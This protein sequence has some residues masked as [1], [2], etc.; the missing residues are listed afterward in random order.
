[1]AG[2]SIGSKDSEG[3]FV[4]S[5]DGSVVPGDVLVI[6]IEV[7]LESVVGVAGVSEM[8]RSE[9]QT[10]VLKALGGVEASVE[11]PLLSPVFSDSV[12]ELELEVVGGLDLGVERSAL[13]KIEPKFDLITHTSS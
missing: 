12:V 1:M 3:E 11:V 2:D 4:L 13:R 6:A 7:N 5:D 10:D 8:R 9:S